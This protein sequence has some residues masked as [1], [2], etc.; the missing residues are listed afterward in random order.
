MASYRVEIE[1][2][3]RMEI[4]QLP[5]NFRQ[6]IVRAIQELRDDPR[7]QNSISLDIGSLQLLADTSAELRRIRMT[8]WRIVY[9]IEDEWRRV[10][11]LTVRKRPPYD[12]DNLA[13]LLRN[14]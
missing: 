12:Y 13:T 8:P 2:T 10:V 1:P 3:C 7:P 4:R 11:V 5:G 6:R 14:L 9:A